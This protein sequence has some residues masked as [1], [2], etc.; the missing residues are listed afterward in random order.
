MGGFDIKSNQVQQ[1]FRK[2]LTSGKNSK[3]HMGDLDIQP[4]QIQ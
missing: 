3:K 2:A 4:G 1:N